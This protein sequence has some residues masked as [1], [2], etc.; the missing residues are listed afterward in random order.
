MFIVGSSNQVQRLLLNSFKK[1]SRSILQSID[2]VFLDE[3]DRL[4]KVPNQYSNDLKKQKLYNN[5]GSA[6]NICQSILNVSPHKVRF[7]CASASITRRHI[8]K[9]D[10]LFEIYRK[11]RNNNTALIRNKLNS[12]N[13]G[14]YVTIPD[15]VKHYYCYSNDDS[16]ESKLNVLV[17]LL[18]NDTTK[19]IIF[20]SNGSLIS[21]K[22]QLIKNNIECN[23]L[24]HELGIKDDIYGDNINPKIK[25]YEDIYK[26]IEKF[27]KKIN[28]SNGRFI[29]NKINNVLDKTI[30]ISSNDSARGLHIPMLETV[31]ILGKPRNVNEYINIAGRVG[32]C[33]RIGRCVTIDS[34]EKIR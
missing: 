34:K 16:I 19:P 29:M 1:D 23:I 7:V 15:T 14:R 5:P 17:E 21:I 6:Y 24:H 8:R 4:I 28:D 25:T 10:R 22:N 2:F 27:Q 26:K 18:K 9:I 11:G 13:T 20:I 3:L 12:T 30:I 33:S 32:R 31:Y